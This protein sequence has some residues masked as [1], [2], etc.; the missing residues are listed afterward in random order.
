[1]S[2]PRYD[3]VIV[4][5]GAGGFTVALTAKTIYKEKSVL[6]VT[7][8]EKIVIPCAIPY[9]VKTIESLDRALLPFDSLRKLGVDIVVD[10]VVDVDRKEKIVV[11]ASGKRFGYDKLILALGGEPITPPI[12]GADLKRVYRVYKGYAPVLELQK[13][14]REANRVV[15]IG[16]GFVGAELADE[17]ADAGKSVTVVEMLPHCLLLNFDEEFATRA[18]EELRKKGVKIITNATVKRIIGR[19]AVEAVEL[20]TGEVIQADTVVIATGY[21]PS[22]KLAEKIGLAVSRYGIVVDSYMRTSDPDIFAVGDCAEK[23]HFLFGEPTPAQLASIAC[24]EARVAVLNL[25][26]PQTSR[27]LDGWVGAFVTKI[28][29]LVI[30]AVGTTERIAKASGID[31]V[32]GRAKAV[33]R[34]PTWLP[35]GCEIDVKLLFMRNGLL[36]VA[37]EA[38]YCNEVAEIINALSMAIQ[39]RMRIDEIITMQFATHPKVTYSPVANPVILAA[40]DAYTKML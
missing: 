38:G 14:L 16:G 26:G 19:D 30:G 37:Q 13:A 20:S 9:V 6:L 10:E 24:Q 11:T 18:E 8:E 34:H 32:V 2:V 36:I 17:L 4:G 1:M 31:C 28:G 35:G 23:R 5:G 15:I 39:N 40:I 25:Y 7:K 12:E 21:R 27:R 22:T 3:I 33:N 29:N